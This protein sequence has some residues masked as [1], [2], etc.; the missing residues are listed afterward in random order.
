MSKAKFGYVC[1]TLNCASVET[2]G[3]GGERF[4]V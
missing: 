3:E 4:E 2:G 1:K